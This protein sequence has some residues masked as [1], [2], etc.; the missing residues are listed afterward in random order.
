VIRHSAF[1]V[2]HWII[3]AVFDRRMT[4]GPN[5]DRMTVICL[6]CEKPL[7]VARKSISV[8]CKHCH[9]SLTFQDIQYKKYESRR[10]I[11]T[12]GVV[13][14]ERKANV[15]SPRIQ[16]GGAV[17]RGQVKGHITSRGPI[18][19]G[20]EAEVKGNVTAPTIAIGAGAILDG[21]Y[22]IGPKDTPPEPPAGEA[23]QTAQ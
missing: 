2:R 7:E 9:K 16:C 14:I 5:E 18:L 3:M 8:T 23:S 17:I 15:V 20:P 13:T 12:L 1:A 22:R 19:V 10:S 6:H 11:E 4:Q 21:D